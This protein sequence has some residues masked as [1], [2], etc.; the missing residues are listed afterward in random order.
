MGILD[1][2]NIVIKAKMNKQTVLY[3]EMVEDINVMFSAQ[4]SMAPE[5]KEIYFRGRSYSVWLHFFC[6]RAFDLKGD[7]GKVHVWNWESENELGLQGRRYSGLR[8]DGGKVRVPYTETLVPVDARCI[9]PF[10]MPKMLKDI[11]RMGLELDDLDLSIGH[12]QMFARRHKIPFDSTTSIGRL[13]LDADSLRQE[14]VDSGYGKSVGA[15]AAKKLPIALLNGRETVPANVPAWVREVAAQI[16]HYREI[17]QKDHAADLVK[18]KKRRHPSRTL[19]SRLN[20]A[21][22]RCVINHVEQRLALKGLLVIAF[23]HDG[24]VGRGLATMLMDFKAEHI[25]LKN[26]RGP[27]TLEDWCRTHNSTLS[28]PAP[29]ADLIGIVVN[30]CLTRGILSLG[31]RYVDHHSFAQFICRELSLRYDFPLFVRERDASENQVF[32]HVSYMF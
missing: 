29:S 23:E 25:Y 14:I 17:E 4:A 11:L 18:L 5:M 19:T 16:E 6:Q 10:M 21:E 12:L 7:F 22:E 32:I 20:E 1:D 8:G 9:G 15:A 13:I 26:K 3:Q 31:C 2:D 24:V 27:Q 28:L 30:D